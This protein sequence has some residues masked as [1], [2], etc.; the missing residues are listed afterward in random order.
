MSFSG[1]SIDNAD[2]TTSTASVT[3]GKRLSKDFY[4]AYESSL[5][6]AMGVIHIFYDLTKHLTL[7]AETG[8]Q[9]AIDLIYTLRYD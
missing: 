5:N 2:G 4:I 8:Q 6:G 9:S 3:L 1:S 7:R